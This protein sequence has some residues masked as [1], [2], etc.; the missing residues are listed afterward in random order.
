VQLDRAV[1]HALALIVRHRLQN[2]GCGA[3]WETVKILGGVLD[4]AAT[5][6][7]PAAAQVLRDELAKSD[8]KAVDVKAATSALEKAFPCP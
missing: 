8:P 6:A 7:D 3:A 4:R 1:D 2:L 5:A